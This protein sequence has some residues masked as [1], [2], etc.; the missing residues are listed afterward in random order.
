MGDLLRGAI[1]KTGDPRD[2]CG[3]ASDPPVG[4]RRHLDN[5]ELA[6]MVVVMASVAAFPGRTSAVSHCP[7]HAHTPLLRAAPFMPIRGIPAGPG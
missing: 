3:D 6:S 2:A 5:W 1:D 4:L 7:A